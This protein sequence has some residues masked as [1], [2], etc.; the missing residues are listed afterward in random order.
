[1]FGNNGD[2]DGA[3]ALRDALK[4]NKTLEFLDL[5]YNRLRENGCRAITDG[6]T[7]NK[8]SA[9]KFISLRYNFIND[10]GIKYFF[11]KAIFKGTKISKA[12]IIQNYLHEHVAHD[13]YA[14]Y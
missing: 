9:L 8:D 13:L 3:R 4:N 10:D 1:M 11:E 7:E 14:K 5:G 2:V 12:F 6:F